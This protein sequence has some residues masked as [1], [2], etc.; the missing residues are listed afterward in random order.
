MATQPAQRAFMAH[1]KAVRDSLLEPQPQAPNDA[2]NENC[3][4]EN[5]PRRRPLPDPLAALRARLD[6]LLD[7]PGPRTAADWDLVAAIRAAKLPGAPPYQGAIEP[8]LLGQALDGLGFDAA[9]M[10]WLA[11]F[12][13]GPAPAR[14]PIPPSATDST[15]FALANRWGAWPHVAAQPDAAPPAAPAPSDADLVTAD[16]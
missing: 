11:G 4:N 3:T 10:A 6:R 2:A 7:G 1:R 5:P 13:T 14:A 12:G 8:V 9:G 16:R 15:T